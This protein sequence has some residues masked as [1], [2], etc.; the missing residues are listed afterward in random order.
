[1]FAAGLI[2]FRETLEVALVV[3]IVLTFFYKTR[4]TRFVSYA[5]RGLIAGISIS[6]ILAVA[7]DVMFGGLDGKGDQLFEGLLMFITAGFLTWMILWVHRQKDMSRKIRARITTHIQQGYGI[8]IFL[9]VATAVFRE[10]TETVL[11]LKTSNITG[12][13]NQLTGALV[14]I[15][16]ALLLGFLLFRYALRVKLSLVFSITSVF[17]LLFAAGLVSH[18][19]HEFQEVGL[20]P[21]FSFDPIINISHIV[22]H[23]GMVGSLLRTLFGYTSKP[24]MFEMFAYGSYML[25]ILWLKH[26]TDV[27]L[28]KRTPKQEN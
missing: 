15:V 13:G 2:T 14:G 25:L 6:I 7:L 28:A 21:V 19:V 18:G 17:L 3:G 26:I 4:Q 22:D 12:S 23:Q 9:L 5:W 27:V 20:F 8:G 16:T 1:M 10:G 11:Y 24:T